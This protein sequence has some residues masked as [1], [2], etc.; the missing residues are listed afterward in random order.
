MQS[1]LCEIV[2]FWKRA[3]VEMQSPSLSAFSGGGHRQRGQPNGTPI[4]S[5]SAEAAAAWKFFP[6]ATS[7]RAQVFN[8]PTQ[9]RSAKPERA[10]QAAAGAAASAVLACCADSSSS[11]TGAVIER[12]TV[13]QDSQLEAVD[14]KISE[15]SRTVSKVEG[16]ILDPDARHRI[17]GRTP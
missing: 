2:C 14:K 13:C 7:P 17:I 8:S 5:R 4:R 11:G 9:D 16:C 10:A 1:G 12:C 6:K 15:A 3:S